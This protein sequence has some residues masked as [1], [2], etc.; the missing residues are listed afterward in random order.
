MFAIMFPSAAF[1][2]AGHGEALRGSFPVTETNG[3]W[4]H[5]AGQV[6]RCDALTILPEA[7]GGDHQLRGAG[8]SVPAD[9]GVCIAGAA[10]TLSG[11]DLRVLS[12]PGVPAGAGG[13]Q[14]IRR[15]RGAAAT[16]QQAA[17][18]SASHGRHGGAARFAVT[19]YAQNAARLSCSQERGAAFCVQVR[20][21]QLRPMMPGPPWVPT[22]MPISIS[23]MGGR[24][25]RAWRR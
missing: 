9:A 23:S 16:Q 6:E 13:V 11:K 20:A 4:L 21:I 5:A 1:L 2:F 3:R 18:A 19:E 8:Q 17:A 25:G 22:T 24:S 14:E 7:H 10:G 12:V 15:S